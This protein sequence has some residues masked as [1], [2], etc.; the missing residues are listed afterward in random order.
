VDSVKS[1]IDQPPVKSLNEKKA[2]SLLNRLI[3]Y[4][5]HLN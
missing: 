3:I 2:G 5:N 1:L 4:L